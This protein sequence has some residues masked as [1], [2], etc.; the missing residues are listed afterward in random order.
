M[1]ISPACM[2]SRFSHGQLCNPMDCSPPGSSARGILRARILEW[3]VMPSSR[4][5]SWPRDRSCV[6]AAPALQAD[7]LPLSHWGYVYIYLL[8]LEPAP[9]PPPPL[10]ITTE[11]RAELP[12]LYS[13]SPPT[14]CFTRGGACMSVALSQSVSFP[15]RPVHRSIHCICTSV[16]ALQLGPAVPVF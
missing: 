11:H 15:S 5:S 2:L 14:V 12:V 6:S 7:S 9:A 13:S 10:Y 1:W 16:P 3:V 4:K 8:L